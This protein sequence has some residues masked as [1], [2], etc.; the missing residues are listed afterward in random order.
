MGNEK[1]F[2]TKLVNDFLEY[3]SDSIFIYHD[4]SIVFA[5]SEAYRLIGINNS[6]KMNI[7]NLIDKI[8]GNSNYKYLF[9]ELIREVEINKNAKSITR[10]FTKNDDL[11][12][13]IHINLIPYKDNF[14][15]AVIIKKDNLL[16][17][18][19]L[20]K[21]KYKKLLDFLPLGVLLTDYDHIKFINEAGV[22]ILG[23]KSFKDIIGKNVKDFVLEDDYED[24]DERSFVLFE[25]E[26][27]AEMIERKII[28]QDGTELY[29]EVLSTPLEHNGKK[30]AISVLK[31][32]TMRKRAEEDAE[33]NKK[34]L[35]EVREYD[36]LKTE[37]F[38]NLSHELKT[39]LNVILGSQQLLSMY[40]EN[41]NSKACTRE[42]IKR[43]LKIM[44]QNCNRLLRLVNNLIDITRIDS[45]FFEM[46]LQNH[47][48]VNIIEEITLSVSEYIEDKGVHLIFDTDTEEKIIA[49]DAD[50]IER[51]M[52][53]LLSNAIKFTKPGDEIKVSIL[54]LENHIN[55]SVRDTGIGI[56]QD[57]LNIIFD[58]FRQVDKSFTR[59]HEG[60]GIGL[61]LVKSL[62]ELHEGSISVKSDY[63]VGSEFIINIPVKVI[64][65][66]EN[67][68][69]DSNKV[70]VDNI[71]RIQVEFSDIYN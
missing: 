19:M 38:S 20:S 14:A 53:N 35:Y 2:K 68:K 71:E 10:K 42:K 6:N 30:F 51:I 41:Y 5:N 26:E 9:E 66:K 52:L 48:I 59:S 44:K 63:G 31:D 12:I 43:N 67:I 36:N 47:N 11:I 28:R 70:E 58:R 65:D 32:I 4:K 22:K 54:D 69:E 29:V 62:V 17:R 3:A 45:G 33:K 18:L 13:D 1:D 49:C 24:F 23:G 56:P 7:E 27:D 61:S 15:H 39:P 25:K 34:L 37:F 46:S 50:R 64:E 57:K 40:T 16:E 55:I 60:S 8:K 21:E